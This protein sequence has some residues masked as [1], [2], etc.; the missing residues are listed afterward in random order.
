MTEHARPLSTVLAYR[1]MLS[2]HLS[3]RVPCSLCDHST[4][5]L[6][7]HGC[8]MLLQA[9]CGGALVFT[10]ACVAL[11]VWCRLTT[12]KSKQP[13]KDG[14]KEAVALQATATA[15][16]EGFSHFPRS[17]L[18]SLLTGMFSSSIS[19]TTALGMD[20]VKLS[21]DASN[22][23]ARAWGRTPV[24][25]PQQSTAANAAHGNECSSSI[26]SGNHALTASSSSSRR[27]VRTFHAMCP[28]WL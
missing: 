11:E 21:E 1:I 22:T 2:S 13:A 5:N 6:T 7:P 19:R 27:F 25:E 17:F 24:Q 9:W 14:P 3:P 15:T 12:P 28:G 18:L 10:V 23:V 20:G 26:S 8:R 16:S 4:H